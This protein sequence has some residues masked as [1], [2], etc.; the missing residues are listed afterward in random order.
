[1]SG[2]LAWIWRIWRQKLPLVLMMTGLTLLSSAVAVAFPW[3]SKY[4]L[5]TLQASL[6]RS[7]PVHESLAL[8]RRI[9]LLFIAVG[10][11]NFFASLFP[12][13]RAATNAAFEYFLRD[14][15]FSTLMGRNAAFVSS[16][17]TGDLVTRLS[18]DISSDGRLSWFLCSGIFRAMEAMGKI[19]FCLAAMAA[20][21]LRLTLLSVIPLPLMIGIF[22]VA[23]HRI[24]A[25]FRRNQEAVSEINSQLEM[26]FSGVR[27]IKAHAAERKYGRFFQEALGRR[28]VTETR[29]ARLDAVLQL[30]Y[31]YIDYF[32][33]IALIFAGGIAAA[34]GRIT[35]GT[36]YAFYNYLGMLVFPILD[37][38][39]LFISAKR[40]W[41]NIDRLEELG[42]ADMEPGDSGLA[43][44]AHDAAGQGAERGT[45]SEGISLSAKNLKFAYRDSGTPAID[46]VSFDLKLGERI[47]VIGPVGCGKSTLLKIL[48]GI[49]RQDEGSI[50]LGTARGNG[51]ARLAYVPQEAVLF[52]GTVRENIAFGAQGDGAGIPGQTLERCLEIAQMA[53]EVAKMPN[54]ADS[55]L[56]ARGASLSGGQRQRLA[57]ARAIAREPDI[58]LLDD[59]TASLDAENERRLM[60]SLSGWSRGL[61]CVIASHRMSTVRFAHRV[62]FMESGRITCIGT[63][64]RLFAENARYRSFVESAD[65]EAHE[66]SAPGREGAASAAFA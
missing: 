25:S 53:A 27:V 26:S 65:R 38:P 39:N 51:P 17:R 50:G 37:I 10:V 2:H 5:D 56:E 64:E 42:D 49:L 62:I 32:A 12:G 48:C 19:V 33:Q 16:F 11:G 4:L 34:R 55:V 66:R 54:G 24:Y 58:L 47:A 30:L 44:G 59:I 9:A 7:A 43:P 52:S 1:M 23:E 13:I 14:R 22:S 28:V 21:D 41:A 61:S 40:S 15:Y 46:G 20:M 45:V 18:D 36:F 29:L 35:I 3:L 6:D 57:I 31:Q 60:D 8:S 63:H